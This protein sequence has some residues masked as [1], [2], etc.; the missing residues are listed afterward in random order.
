MRVTGN[1]LRAVIPIIC[2][3]PQS[4]SKSRSVGEDDFFL[5]PQSRSETRSVGKD[6]NGGRD[7]A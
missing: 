3:V 4:R 1:T 2:L 7:A 6:K 5:V